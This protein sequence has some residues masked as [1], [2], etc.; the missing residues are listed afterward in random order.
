[1]INFECIIEAIKRLRGFFSAAQAGT[2]SGPNI[3]IFH[4]GIKNLII[5][6]RN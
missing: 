2:G 1:M 4:A 5:Q 3:S 6:Q